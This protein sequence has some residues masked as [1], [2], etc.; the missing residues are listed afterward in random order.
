MEQVFYEIFANVKTPIH[1]GSGLVLVGHPVSDASLLVEA[2]G[3]Q[4][5]G[6]DQEIAAAHQLGSLRVGQPMFSTE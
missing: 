6:G 3:K 4:L 2:R 5:S 1:I